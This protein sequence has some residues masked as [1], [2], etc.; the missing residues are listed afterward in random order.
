MKFNVP[1]HGAVE[2]DGV[3]PASVAALRL[4]QYHA[5]KLIVSVKT[6]AGTLIMELK[7]IDLSPSFSKGVILPP[8]V[9]NKDRAQ[10]EKLGSSK[11]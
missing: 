8:P 5:P 4:V 7:D 6:P 9:L 11:G 10:L 2:I 3:T 1:V